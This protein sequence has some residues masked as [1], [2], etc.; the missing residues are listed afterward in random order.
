MLRQR[1]PMKK[2]PIG[3]EA[4]R[5]DR[6]DEMEKSLT[7][8]QSAV[9]V[10][11]LA[12]LWLLKH[13]YK[14]IWHD[15]T[16]YTFL[17]LNRIHPEVYGGDL[18]T[19]FGS[20]DAYTVF[21]QVYAGLI[22]VFGIHN[23]AMMLTILGQLLWVFAAVVFF[24]MF[25]KGKELYI[26]LAIV[27]FMKSHY[28][29][30]G[31]FQF[32]ETFASPRIFS[33]ALCILG[34]TAM[35]KGRHALF[36]VLFLVAFFIHPLMTIGAGFIVY[37]YVALSY[38]RFLFTAP[39]I[40]GAVFL[41]GLFNIEPFAGIYRT[42]SPEWLQ[43][44]HIRSS[45]MF[46]FQWPLDDWAELF[47]TLSIIAAALL[48]VRGA[49]RRL[50]LSSIIGA[51]CGMLL[52][53][54][55]G[56]IL[57]I[58]L[59]MQIQAWRSLW[60][61][62]FASALASAAIIFFFFR[63]KENTLLLCSFF[64]LTWY[65]LSLG[66]VSFLITSIFLYLT[67]KASRENLPPIELTR[68]VIAVIA[69]VVLLGIIP[70]IMIFDKSGFDTLISLQVAEYAMLHFFS[71]LILS[72]VIFLFF[73]RLDRIPNPNLVIATSAVLIFSLA[74][75]DR[76]S[77]WSRMLENNQENNTF[78]RNVLP[79]NAVVLWDGSSDIP[80]LGSMRQSYVSAQQ[81][82]G[83]VFHEKT[84]LEYEKRVNHIL[85]LMD[86]NPLESREI[87][88]TLAWRVDE[89]KFKANYLDVCRNAD[90]LD[91]VI[92]TVDIQG[93]A[94]AHWRSSV[95][96]E[97]ARFLDDDTFEKTKNQDFYLYDCRQ[98]KKR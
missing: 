56:E 91:Y 36:A 17:A 42:L 76:Q 41:P 30:F 46:L 79:E 33:E 65:S 8:K 73:Y 39:I 77:A 14:G 3:W 71:P 67:V 89:N 22:K 57:K 98:F 44:V 68:P 34:T 25:F 47:L 27:F 92:S 1:R 70:L 53:L 86:E 48:I 74:A 93:R 28:G 23:S 6:L 69:A 40:A 13:P 38:P 81:G 2:Q 51:C 15:S 63:L 35:M 61:L 60:L 54:I 87:G 88:Y 66:A 26:A 31:A 62:Q 96:M 12:S 45:F 58:E 50:L 90:D 32:A 9:V 64:V 24:R 97:K 16:L 43:I 21:P 29:G 5:G 78:F 80:W 85:P 19:K 84:A 11:I 72:L 10:S 18:F 7:L 49:M 83:V 55:G 95:P 59:V 4:R 37:V 52:N 94:T 82:S 75:W 20:Q